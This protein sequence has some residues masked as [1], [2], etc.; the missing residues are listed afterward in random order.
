M[1]AIWRFDI[2]RNISFL[3]SS[4][5]HFYKFQFRFE[6]QH[7]VY[8]DMWNVWSR[9]MWEVNEKKTQISVATNC[10]SLECHRC[11]FITQISWLYLQTLVWWL[12]QF[13]S[14]ARIIP[15][16]I[17]AMTWYLK[18]KRARGKN[19][20]LKTHFSVTHELMRFKAINQ[21]RQIHSPIS[22][23]NLLIYRPF[24]TL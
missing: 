18:T 17:K 12:E 16:C 23:S 10:G 9:K 19:E 3:T 21:T 13:L 14:I 2:S 22:Q 6:R 20:T 4:N 1:L 5:K 11:R 24:Q 15:L 7:L 8:H